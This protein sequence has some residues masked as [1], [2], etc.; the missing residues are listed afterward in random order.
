[1]AWHARGRTGAAVAIVAV[2]VCAVAAVLAYPGR[3]ALTEEGT[4]FVCDSAASMCGSSPAAKVSVTALSELA[5]YRAA[6]DA[7]VAAKLEASDFATYRGANDAAVAAKLDAGEFTTYR[8]AADAAVAKKVDLAD[9]KAFRS[10]AD[11]AVAKKIDAADF[12]AFRTA[13]DAA[14]ASKVDVA[15]FGAYRTA[16]DAAVAA[17]LARPLAPVP[18]QQ[19]FAMSA[20]S[21]TGAASA[22]APSATGDQV[23]RG[24]GDPDWFRI[25]PQNANVAANAGTAVFNGLAV[26]DG[27]G[28]SVGKLQ[29]AP[30]GHALV[31]KV[32]KVGH[33]LGGD[34]L[35]TAVVTAVKAPGDAA[36]A[37]FRGSQ[38][39]THLPWSDDNTYIRAGKDGG[40]IRIGDQGSPAAV[41]LGQ[42]ETRVEVKGDMN[43]RR[44]ANVQGRLHFS[45]PAMRTT[46]DMGANNSDPY[47]LQKITTGDNKS[48]LRL[49]INDDHD[50]AF[51]VWGNAC[52]VGDCAGPGALQ[53]MFR[54]QGDTFHRADVRIGGDM[55]FVGGNNWVIHTPDDNR[56]AMYITPSRAYGSEDWNWEAQTRFEPDG[57]VISRN[58]LIAS[59]ARYKERIADVPQRDV[60]GLDALRPRQYTLKGDSEGRTHFG[61]VAQ[62]VEAVYPEL[63]RADAESGLKSVNYN[64]VVPLAVAGVQQVRRQA[65]GDRLCIGDTCV[66]EAELAQLKTLL[67]RP[68]S[69]K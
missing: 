56:R 48:S 19:P 29:K 66:N 33:Q 26:T 1:M 68:A 23:G 38:L 42:G 7:A 51:E 69:S 39:W 5:A 9:F 47:W 13:T 15:D 3:E 64:E 52:A 46:P 57:S 20:P 30:E 11:A 24:K 55:K 35:D 6:N 40:V 43:V 14:V 22:S 62:E 18:Q 16:N 59:D 4:T 28:L 10:A 32:L 21:A 63:V 60:D 50:E 41:E 34:W 45:D 61:F 53:H 67:R 25:N 31:S 49:T 65:R 37:S 8:S 27:G 12:R 54:A 58:Q 36:G 17:L 44:H 2:V